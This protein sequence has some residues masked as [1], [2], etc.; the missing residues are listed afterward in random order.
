MLD[1]GATG[2]FINQH[3]ISRKGIPTYQLTRELPLYNIDGT[4]NRAGTISQFARL[5]LRVGDHDKEWDFLV[6][7]LG[8]EDLILG[9]PWLREVNPSI[10]WSEGI[11][12]T[13]A[14]ARPQQISA[15]R[16]LRRSWIRAGVLETGDE[17]WMCAGYT[18]SQKIAEEQNKAKEGKSFEEMVPEEYRRYA[19]VFSE[20][21]SH[22]LPEHK[23]WD[24]TIDLK[25]D[26]PETLH[27]RVFPMSQPEDEELGRF[28][29]DALAKGYI[30]PSKSPMASPVFFVKK[31]DGRLRLCP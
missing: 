27:A 22:R 1:S 15:N 26:A 4:K 18:Y 13:A 10:D 21:E 19:K 2:L 7:E 31:K 29:E 5:R 14:E 25:P 12:D 3:Y 8:P 24:H 17:L 23:P 6:T 11:L 30:V 9:L 28:L 20:E 16:K